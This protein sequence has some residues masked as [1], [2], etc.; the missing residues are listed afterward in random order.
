[1]KQLFSHTLLVLL[2]PLAAI[3]Q[4]QFTASLDSK[5]VP[6]GEAF[7]IKFT[8]DNGQGSGFRPPSFGEFNVVSGPNR[9][10]SMTIVNGNSRSSESIV[11]VLQ[12]KKE[13]IFTIGSAS[14]TINGKPYT[15]QPLS[16]SVSKGKRQTPDDI[17]G[18]KGDVFI[19]AEVSSTTAYIGQQIIL[20]Y[21]LYT[22]ANISGVSRVNE[23]KYDG[24][25]KQE[26][27][28]FPHNDNRVSVGGKE[29]ISRI[30]QRLAL[31]PQREGS[32]TVEPFSLQMGIV[33]G[34]RK[35]DDDPF[36]SFFSAP[37]VE[38]RIVSANE[39]SINVKALP[40]DAP[41]SFS[42]A[43]G[44]FK[45][46]FSISK[47][48]ATTDDVISLKI[49]VTGNGDAKRWQAPKLNNI[50]GLEIY[51]A[52]IVKEE[53]IERSGEWQTTKEIEYL[54]V[55][56]QTGSFRLEP[57]FSFFDT[58]G[59]RF[60]T[61]K[62]SFDLKIAQGQNKAATLLQDKI[63]D[64]LGIK[65]VTVFQNQVIRFWGS[66]LFFALLIL[67]FLGLGGV[68]LYREWQIR[69][70]QRDKNLLRRTNAPKIAENRLQLAHEFL[71]KGNERLFYD[72]VSKALFN[73]VSDKF[74]I[75]LAE[76][77]KNNVREKLDSLK[78]KDSHIDN[79]MQ[80]LNSCELALFSGRNTEGGASAIYAKAIK[81]I[82]DIE[83]DLK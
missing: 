62:Q 22:R 79:F 58:E 4:V 12:A 65:T 24:F 30:L 41:A 25:F 78:I 63:K 47:T 27:N 17:K 26:V 40:T 43:V 23:S 67:P 52:K 7:E 57:E 10:N 36:G 44:D 21:K 48:E 6:V 59:G 39:V 61:L 19:R 35:D 1:M 37:L 69:L 56:K 20:D 15:T 72:E 5:Q 80:I 34:N 54:I 60:Q 16:I 64:I 3:G 45:A 29:Y 2:F 32:M 50:N 75:S 38:N 83:E 73:Y 11:Y 82:V 33:K 81:V 14:V 55:P 9:M 18:N 31:Y 68:I 28:D 13:G 49:N 70:N 74:G 76:F 8:I 77:T 53:S 51:E 71:N 42:G 46:D 66:S